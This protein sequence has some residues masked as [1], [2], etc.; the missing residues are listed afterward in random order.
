MKVDSS[1][2][3]NK[4]E[5]KF[6]RKVNRIKFNAFGKVTKKSNKFLSN[7][8]ELVKK[9]SSAESNDDKKELEHK[10]GTE[11]IKEK[12]DEIERQINRIKESA[13]T[14]QSQVFKLRNIL[15]N[16]ENTKEIE[17][18]V[19]PKTKKLI[20]DKE[21][22]L[23]ATKEY[24]S[25]VLQNNRPVEKYEQF[26]NVISKCHDIRMKRQSN[27]NDEDDAVE[28]LSRDDFDKEIKSLRSK[29]KARYKDITEAGEGFKEDVYRFMK[30]IWDM[31]EIPKNWD[32]TTLVQVFKR[33][34]RNEL[35]SYRYIHLKE[36]RPRL[37]DGLVFSKMKNKLIE[38]MSKYQI[39][40]KPGHRPQEHLF[41]LKSFLAIQKY[42]KDIVILQTFDIQAY[43]DRTVL[44][45]SM[46]CL[47]EA[48]VPEK[49]YRLTYNLNKNTV[50]Q[51][52][53]AAG[54]TDTAETGENLGQGSKSAGLICSTGLSM[55]VS[56]FFDGSNHEVSYG[57]VQLAPLLYQDDSMRMTNSVDGARD[58]IRRFEELM[59]AKRLD[60]NI[61]K[62][63][64]MIFGKK[65]NVDRIRNEIQNNPLYYKG[66]AM[67]EKK[68]EK[69]L[70]DFI[71][72]LGL[73]ES[74]LTTIQERKQRIFTAINEVI[75]IIED[76]RVNRLGSLKFA[77][78]IWELVIVPALLNNGEVW[79]FL[80][81]KVQTT[82]EDIQSHFVRGLMAV[83]K[84]CPRPALAY[85]ANLLK[86]KYRLYK[87][88]LNFLKHLHSLD[89]S[90]LAKQILSEMINNDWQ[91]L[92]KDVQSACQ[93]LNVSHTLFD[94]EVSKYKFKKY[95]KSVCRTQNDA[96]LYS[97][98]KE[99]K[100]MKAIQDEICKGNK[101]FFQENLYNAR[102]IFRFRV[103]LTESKMNFKNKYEYKCE[104]YMCD[105][106]QS[107]IDEN[108]HVLFCHS[109]K[110]LR[111]GLDMNN[112]RDLAQ[113]LQKV[114]N[115]R[116][117]L[118]LN[119]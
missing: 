69:W 17:A 16:K 8:P 26:Y 55:G 63:A 39:G 82:L 85:E 72:V 42:E 112:D 75:A 19:N 58:G 108:T 106:C 67:K 98:I 12:Y 100:K 13:K 93:E 91:G 33:G 31:E 74:T 60:V 99:Y 101:Y 9:R 87:K 23:Q 104:K 73:K 5:E 103:E 1:S 78:D 115:I 52:K 80:D 76:S 70:G 71:D 32:L 43:F 34:N 81:K 44:L 107:E 62:C 21:E 35:S 20:V 51:V 89:D 119:R 36:W 48:N 110:N 38:N 46:D 61:D 30:F 45:E 18:I 47:A 95:V 118:R 7:I 40:A 84:S 77:V 27:S 68:K 2:D 4:M 3:V 86:M 50:V 105:S 83:P 102:V 96:E 53:T 59:D 56:K 117:K 37:L 88:S 29:G 92:Y 109:Y 41:V 114:M 64:Y 6:E 24:A 79:S 113:Y 57:R 28:E 49:C 25:C 65:K 94:P 11:F 116:M 90:T 66:T 54:I 22:I 97:E 15:S 111:D 10:I 14:H